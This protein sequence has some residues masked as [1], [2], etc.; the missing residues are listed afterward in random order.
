MSINKFIL[1]FLLLSFFSLDGRM[2]AAPET[3]SVDIKI[4]LFDQYTETQLRQKI[5]SVNTFDKI[6]AGYLIGKLQYNN[7]NYAQSY[8]NFREV[9]D[10]YIKFIS[11]E[12]TYKLKVNCGLALMEMRQF[13]ES[14]SYLKSANLILDKNNVVESALLTKD[15]GT[16]YFEWGKYDTASIY[17]QRAEIL[18][19]ETNNEKPLA[20]IYNKLGTIAHFY[21]SLNTAIK[22]YQKAQAIAEKYNL[23][24]ELSEALINLGIEYRETMEFDNSAKTLRKALN[25]SKSINYKVG[26]IYALNAIAELFVEKKDYSKALEFLQ[27]SDSMSQG[28]DDLE[29]KIIVLNNIGTVYKLMKQFDKSLDIFMEIENIQLANGHNPANTELVIGEIYK[30]QSNLDMAIDYLGRSRQKFSESKN[31]P[32]C[33]SVDFQIAEIYIRQKNTTKAEQILLNLL[34]EIKKEKLDIYTETESGIYLRLSELYASQNDAYKALLYYKEYEKLKAQKQDKAYSFEL[35]QIENDTKL[36]KLD[37]QIK[38]KVLEIDYQRKKSIAFIIIAFFFISLSVFL[39]KLYTDKNKLYTELVKRNLELAKQLPFQEEKAALNKITETEL[40]KSKEIID[41]LIL[42]FESKQVYLQKDINIEQ[43][44]EMLGTNRTY[45]S[46][47]IR[48]V[49]DSNYNLLINKYRVEKARKLLTE[50]EQKL[51][52]EGIARSV[53]FSSKSTFNVAFKNFTGLTPSYL[54]DEVMKKNVES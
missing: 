4:K 17:F 38:A 35:A 37:A 21:N 41:K 23:K 14:L 33:Y 2:N 8:L 45:L 20:G 18:L 47:A 52:I 27:K 15:I 28:I 40:T 36:F 44:A 39:F 22:F 34:E 5:I 26:E 42:L 12:F 24:T 29:I 54:R 7:K 10:K 6:A 32:G 13:N 9:L 1:T 50:K 30:L 19:I 49:L 46:K 53:G 3:D 31:N 16:V 43:I 25:Y 48:D 51:S 11:T